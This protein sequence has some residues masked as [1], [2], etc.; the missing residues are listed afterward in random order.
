MIH[1]WITHSIR[2]APSALSR[3]DADSGAAPPDPTAATHSTLCLRHQSP[4]G[5]RPVRAGRAAIAPF[6]HLDYLRLHVG[7]WRPD[8]TREKRHDHRISAIS[9]AGPTSDSV[10]AQARLLDRVALRLGIALVEWANRA[11]ADQSARIE[12]RLRRGERAQNPVRRTRRGRTNGR[13]PSP[14]SSSATCS[15]PRRLGDHVPLPCGD[16]ADLDP[17]PDRGVVA[18]HIHQNSENARH[19]LRAGARGAIFFL[20]PTQ[21]GAGTL[22]ISDQRTRYAGAAGFVGASP[23]R[24]G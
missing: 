10:P 18:H 4:V 21:K 23:V 17:Q 11:E 20:T 22:M 9:H 12:R 1:E 7:R 14:R 19:K 5:D 24:N 16:L 8:S 3:S 2:P 6:R 15:D 13:R